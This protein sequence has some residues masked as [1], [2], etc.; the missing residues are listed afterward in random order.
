MAPSLDTVG[1]FARNAKLMS[2]VG[3][4]LLGKGAPRRG[5]KRPAKVLVLEDVLEVSEKGVRDAIHVAAAAARAV[6]GE[7]AVGYMSLSKCLFDDEELRSSL[8]PFIAGDELT[9]H[10][11][12]WPAILEALRQLQA[13]EF[14]K[15]HGPWISE[16]RAAVG[17][18]IMKQRIAPTELVTE[19]QMKLALEARSALR[20]CLR[21][22]LAGSTVMMLPTLPMKPVKRATKSSVERLAAFRVRCRTILALCSL[23]GSPQLAMPV[24]SK[25]AS[26]EACAGT[27]VDTW[28]PSVSIAGRPGT[29]LLLLDF[30]LL[31]EAAIHQRFIAMQAASVPA[32]TLAPS[33]AETAPAETVMDATTM[34]AK[35]E[36]ELGNAKF[37]EGDYRA[38]IVHYTAAISTVDAS[39]KATVY[40]NRALAFLSLDQYDLAED[41]CNKCL[42]LNPTSVK[43]LMRRGMA[44]AHMNRLE[45]ALGDFQR[46]LQLE[47]HNRQA[48]EEISRMQSLASQLLK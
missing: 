12:V 4:T 36:K 24:R 44:R 22:L 13:R 3:Y 15:I 33:V 47:P 29:D 45:E 38:A 25:E 8:A 48:K 43:A 14:W 27:S 5:N 37:K 19:E 35:R 31:L 18:V 34:A 28:E 17:T 16:N 41:D 23:S 40:G 46:V 21:S 26:A 42:K 10:A 6:L 32:D 11:D 39:Q 30:A 7:Q 20:K 1:F 9:S 2:D